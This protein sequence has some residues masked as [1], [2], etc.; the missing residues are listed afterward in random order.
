[1]EVSEKRKWRSPWQKNNLV[2]GRTQKQKK[3]PCPL[4]S[5][6]GRVNKTGGRGLALK[7][8]GGPNGNHSELTGG[9][10]R[11]LTGNCAP[12]RGG[13]FFLYEQK[14]GRGQRGNPFREKHMIQGHRAV[15]FGEDRILGGVRRKD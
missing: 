8:R 12:E 14:G 9:G 2:K 1:V 3:P 10:P 11:V 7:G 4:K 15:E 13:W 6:V 5:I